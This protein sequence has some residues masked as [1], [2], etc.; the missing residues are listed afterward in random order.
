MASM[1]SVLEQPPLIVEQRDV[2]GTMPPKHLPTTT[3]KHVYRVNFHGG[4]I[5]SLVQAETEERAVEIAN[6]PLQR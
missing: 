1:K 2:D 4:S 5:F 3:P 6:P